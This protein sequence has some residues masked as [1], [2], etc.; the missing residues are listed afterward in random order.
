VSR[1]KVEIVRRIYEAV[2]A[3]DAATVLSL[4]DPQVELD[5]SASPFR[6]VLNRSVYRGID[7]MRQFIR[8]RYEA[9]EDPGD[10]C[11]DLIPAGEYVISVVT[12]HGRGRASGAEVTR[13][14]YGVWAFRAGKVA[15]VTWYGDRAEA[16]A[17]AGAAQ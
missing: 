9:L 4:Y 5:F 10:R 13:V 1:E 17:A 7:E 3:R 12:S 6:E 16:L 2:D 15:R 8:E 14:H 11:D